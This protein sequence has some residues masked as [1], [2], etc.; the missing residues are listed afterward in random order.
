MPEITI[1][2][3]VYNKVAGFKQVVEE[4]IESEIEND[5]Y[6]EFVLGKGVDSLLYDLISPLKQKTLLN[7][8]KILGSRYPD[9]VYGFIAEVIKKGASEE[10][11]KSYKRQIGYIQEDDVQNE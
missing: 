6:I 8:I 5:S 7:S 1:S 9:Q 3:D 4:V 11:R 10:T 2:D